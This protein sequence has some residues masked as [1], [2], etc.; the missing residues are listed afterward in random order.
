MY[1]L[2]FLQIIEAAFTKTHPWPLGKLLYIREKMFSKNKMIAR[3]I[4]NLSLDKIFEE[5][6][7]ANDA[8]NKKL[9]DNLYLID[10]K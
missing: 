10:K 3:N 8:L 1:N 7:Q 2:L 6:A 4:W 5:F 9:E